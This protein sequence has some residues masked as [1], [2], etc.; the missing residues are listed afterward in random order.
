MYAFSRYTLDY[1]PSF[2]L[3][4][5]RLVATALVLGFVLARAGRLRLA[6]SEWRDA[7]ALGLV[8]FVISLGAQFVGTHLA[9]AANGSLITSTSPAFIVL[10]A[11]LLLKEP[12]TLRKA[13]AIL[14]ATAGVVVVIGPAE[15]LR[16]NAGP[17]L[18]GKLLLVVAGLTWG[19]YTVM[20]KRFSARH[21]ALATTA[22][23]SITGAVMNLP[24]AIVEPKLV[25]MADW[26]LLAW[27]GIAYISLISTAVAFYLYNLGFE[28][29]DAGSAAVFFFAQPVVGSL[30]GW[31]LLDEPL[32]MGFFV[33]G[34]LIAIG[35]ILANLQE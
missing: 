30:L 2:T 7:A 31:W 17:A 34:V 4:T 12:I 18:T 3:L 9:G 21:G 1:V 5:I 20:G 29:L 32:G 28:L 6:R 26:P 27:I 24:I 10:F 23:A 19:L 35:V 13:L 25:P 14:L 15:L 16:G 33:G 8:G 22:W 11:A